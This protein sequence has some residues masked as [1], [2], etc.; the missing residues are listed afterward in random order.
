MDKLYVFGNDNT[1]LEW[2]SRY[3]PKLDLIK[4]VETGNILFNYL[5]C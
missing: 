4:I 1:L 5:Y 2:L 3:F